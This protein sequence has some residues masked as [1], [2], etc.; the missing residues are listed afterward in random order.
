M[1]RLIDKLREISYLMKNLF[2]KQFLTV[3]INKIR[4][5]ILGKIGMYHLV[6]DITDSSISINDEVII[7]VNPLYIDSKIR[8]EYI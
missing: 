3:S 4:Y 7:D 1:F 6:I 2:K 8:R 5:N